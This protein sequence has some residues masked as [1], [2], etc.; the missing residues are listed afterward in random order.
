MGNPVIHFEIGCQNLAETV[1]FYAKLFD[2][3]MEDMGPATLIRT[4]A[5]VGGH[6]TA[7]GPPP[8]STRCFMSESMMSRQR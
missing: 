2:W 1:E 4:G 8:T 3:K 7:L 6:I 5:E